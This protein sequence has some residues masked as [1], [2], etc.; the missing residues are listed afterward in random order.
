MF[1]TIE[2]VYR[3][4]KVEFSKTPQSCPDFTFHTRRTTIRITH[5]LSSSN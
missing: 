1:T 4:G 3:K 5:R 2:G